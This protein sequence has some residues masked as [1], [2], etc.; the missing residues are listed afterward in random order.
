MKGAAIKKLGWGAAWSD[1]NWLSHVDKTLVHSPLVKKTR[2][3]SVCA[4]AIICSHRDKARI[5]LLFFLNP[6]LFHIYCIAK[7]ICLELKSCGL[8]EPASASILAVRLKKMTSGPLM[9]ECQSSVGG[10]P[11]GSLA[12]PRHR[13]GACNQVSCLWVSEH[14]T[15]SQVWTCKSK[16]D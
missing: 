6:K 13:L 11:I 16:L 12:V 2:F 1:I 9:D 15:L 5:M 3:R 8:L 14:S 10:K 4:N 7:N